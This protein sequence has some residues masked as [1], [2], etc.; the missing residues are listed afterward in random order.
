MPISAIILTLNEEENIQACLKTLTFCDEVLVVDTGSSD[1]TISLAT[2]ARARVL[3]R[4]LEGN[5][6]S[7]RNKAM[8][9]ATNDLILFIDADERITPK[10]QK[11]IQ[12]VAS[13]SGSY[14]YL[15]KRRDFFLE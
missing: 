12:K 11:S 1:K 10:L 8:E 2:K 6:A 4:T 3:E 7:L 14:N 13:L 5:F 9:L 15:I